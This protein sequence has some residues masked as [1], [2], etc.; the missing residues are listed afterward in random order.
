MTASA[1]LEFRD[2]TP[3]GYLCFNVV[4]IGADEWRG[5]LEHIVSFMLNGGEFRA[6]AVNRETDEPRVIEAHSI[7]HAHDLLLRMNGRCAAA[8][9]D[10]MLSAGRCPRTQHEADIVCNWMNDLASVWGGR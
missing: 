3:D 2:S 6:L 4:P 10:H 7:K 1:R 9:F 8:A 5:G